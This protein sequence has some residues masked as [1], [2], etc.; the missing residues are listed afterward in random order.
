[1]A[2]EAVSAKLPT[3]LEG[4]NLS[5]RG[6]AFRTMCE[7]HVLELFG[8]LL[9][10]MQLGETSCSYGSA[11]TWGMC[12]TSSFFFSLKSAI[13]PS[14]SLATSFL[15][16]GT[17]LSPPGQFTEAT[18]VAGGARNVANRHPAML[19]PRIS[20]LASS[21]AAEGPESFSITA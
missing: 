21:A 19:V 7:L 14:A 1:M 4:Q 12:G 9:C 18:A 8:C 20:R 6:A 16:A 13:T 15:R 10:L 3:L 17:K 5:S 11:G 2:S